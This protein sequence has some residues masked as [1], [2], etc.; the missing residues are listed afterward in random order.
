MPRGYL[1]HLIVQFLLVEPCAEY[2]AER[3]VLLSIA[4]VP[5]PRAT[6]YLLDNADDGQAATRRNL[7]NQVDSEH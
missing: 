4:A 1:R 3:S 7:G 5:V 6:W 2:I